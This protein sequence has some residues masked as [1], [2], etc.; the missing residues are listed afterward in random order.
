MY[1]MVGIDTEKIDVKDDVEFSQRLVK[2][3][4]VFVLPG[5]VF[6]MPNY[7]RMVITSPEQVMTEACDRIRAFC[8][9]NARN[10]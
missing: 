5:Q 7:F 2:E 3:E 9:R 10:H 4:S 1:V 8:E 6:Q